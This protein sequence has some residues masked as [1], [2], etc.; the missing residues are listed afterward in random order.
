MFIYLSNEDVFFMKPKDFFLSETRTL[1]FLFILFFVSIIF[2]SIRNVIIFFFLKNKGAGGGVSEWDWDW[3]LELVCVPPRLE[4][5]SRGRRA[6]AI[7]SGGLQSISIHNNYTLVCVFLQ[8]KIWFQ[9]RRARERREREASQRAQL[10]TH[11]PYQPLSIPSVTW[12]LTSQLTP[13]PF[14]AQYRNE[15]NFRAG[16]FSSAFS[17]FSAP[18]R[19][20]GGG[21]PAPE[22]KSPSSACSWADK[23]N[24][25]DDSF[26]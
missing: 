2:V 1:V 26:Y 16:L 9:N 18:V 11:K 19:H 3:S 24:S 13:S 4:R 21:G 12:A 5:R 15:L 7:G 22:I 14:S 17:A 6:Y 23:H 10:L 20:E 25:D 8:V